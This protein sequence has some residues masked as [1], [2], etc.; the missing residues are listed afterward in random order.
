MCYCDAFEETNQQWSTDI[1]RK[2][3]KR[4]ASVLKLLIVSSP[5][6]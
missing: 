4:I 5:S 1:E 6:Q 3:W 2:Q